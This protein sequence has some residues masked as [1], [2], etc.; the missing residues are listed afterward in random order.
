VRF[1]KE[2]I[3]NYLNSSDEQIDPYEVM[4]SNAVRE[5]PQ[6][7]QTVFEL[8]RLFARPRI[9]SLNH[10]TIGV[11]GTPLSYL[12]VLLEGVNIGS[13]IGRTLDKRQLRSA[14]TPELQLESQ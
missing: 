3:K 13:I 12:E 4:K 7:I 1:Y 5:D 14:V 2:S 10:E 9:N 6:Y 8:A 11:T